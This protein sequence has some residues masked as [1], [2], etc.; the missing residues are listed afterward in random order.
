MSEQEGLFLEHI[1]FEHR[2]RMFGSMHYLPIVYLIPDEIAEK[3]G[4]ADFPRDP[5][6]AATEDKWLDVYNSNYFQMNLMD[7]ISWMMWQHLGIRGGIENYSIRNPISIMVYDLGMWVWLLAEV[8]I[9]LDTLSALPHGKEI[10]FLT[11]EESS[12]ICNALA[13]AF[14]NHPDLKMRKVHEIVSTHRSHDDY[15][16]RPSHAKMDF[17]RHYYHT[18][19]KTKVEPIISGYDEDGEEEIVY[20]PYTPNEFAE[21]EFRIWFDGFL[22]QLS[23]KD[24]QIIKLLEQGYTQEEI[25]EMLGYAN[26]SG[27]TKRIMYIRKALTDFK[28]ADAE[29]VKWKPQRKI[30]TTK[31]KDAEQ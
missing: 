29:G 19:A 27:V 22:E 20:A 10:P 18:R 12:E 25:A 2:R 31:S 11:M 6:I 23:E 4:L 28:K 13:N 9:D 15:S 21:V 24:Q 8:G 1:V 16:S 3:R 26:H 5:Y 17:H 7:T 30:R 14:W